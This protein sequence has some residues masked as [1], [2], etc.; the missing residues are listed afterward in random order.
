MSVLRKA[1]PDLGFTE[2]T[3]QENPPR[4]KNSDHNKVVVGMF[5]R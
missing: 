2:R 5:N 1:V 4:E 3:Y